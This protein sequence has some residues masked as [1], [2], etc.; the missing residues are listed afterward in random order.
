MLFVYKAYS[1]MRMNTIVFSPFVKGTLSAF[2]TNFKNSDV[3][4][5]F[6]ETIMAL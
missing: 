4:S 3:S 1:S 2:K 5:S 6:P